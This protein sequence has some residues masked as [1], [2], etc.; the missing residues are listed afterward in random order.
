MIRKLFL[1]DIIRGKRY[2]SESVMSIS[3]EKDIIRSAIIRHTSQGVKLEKVLEY[4]IPQ[5]EKQA[6]NSK[7]AQP[8][9]ESLLESIKNEA[10]KHDRVRLIIPS[11]TTI[12]REIELPFSD[13]EKIGMV[14]E[15]EVEGALPFEISD[16]ILDIIIPSSKTANGTVQTLVIATQKTT[17]ERQLSYW[18]PVNLIPDNITTD[19]LSLYGLTTYLSKKSTPDHQ[20]LIYFDSTKI[21]IGFIEKNQLRTIRTLSHGINELKT[22][23]SEAEQEEFDQKFTLHGL[24]TSPDEIYNATLDK[25][26]KKIIQEIAFAL[27]S[28]QMQANNMGVIEKIIVVQHG[29]PIKGLYDVLNKALNIP[30]IPLS[31][32]PLVANR[33]L[34]NNATSNAQALLPYLLVIGAGMPPANQVDFD[35]GGHLNIEASRPLI[36]KQLIAGCLLIASIT[37]MLGLDGYF[38]VASL[39]TQA[40]NLEQK[41]SQELKKLFPKGYKLPRNKSLKRLIKEADGYT[42][43]RQASWQQFGYKGLPALE[44]M[45]ELTRIIDRNKYNVV[46]DSFEMSK[47]EAGESIAT[48]KG[49]MKAKDDRIKEF[50]DLAER[51]HASKQL[52]TQQFDGTYDDAT[53]STTFVGTLRLEEV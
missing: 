33:S 16:A 8:E 14:V 27:D 13:P 40:S 3:L 26:M 1:P 24:L 48:I 4:P 23:S 2:F 6:S 47:N 22:A 50:T 5:E 30:C 35:L 41:A 9:L 36:K 31:V 53:D 15:Y 46:M 25:R 43:D 17:I 20:A 45:L 10:E 39:A 28:F 19:L 18:K 29:S 32:E 37:L 51:L 49:S 11:E 7:T 52:I 21:K 12:L 38:Q 34:I 42:T 44:T